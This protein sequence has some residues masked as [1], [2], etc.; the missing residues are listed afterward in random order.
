MWEEAGRVLV[1]I[2][3]AGVLGAVGRL[4]VLGL[5]AFYQSRSR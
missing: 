2:G 3:A 5:R 4:V 1:M